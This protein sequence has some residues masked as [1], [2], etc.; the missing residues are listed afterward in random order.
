MDDCWDLPPT[1]TRHNLVH[2]DEDP[3]Q[4]PDQVSRSRKRSREYDPTFSSDPALFSSD[5]FLDTSADD[6]LLSNRKKKYR[7]TW[8]DKQAVEEP[9]F[10]NQPRKREFKR[11]T[12]SG[13]W[14]DED[15]TQDLMDKSSL[16]M[17]PSTFQVR[18]KSLS[19]R[20]TKRPP[21]DLTL[22]I[23]DSHSSGVY[24]RTEPTDEP[25]ESAEAIESRRKTTVFYPDISDAPNAAAARIVDR[26]VENGIAAVDLS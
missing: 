23:E 18:S 9:R 26:C 5:D 15:D 25:T 20:T 3:Y 13:I 6:Y 21:S 1:C 14:V 16:T 19:E 2:Q 10:G 24:N 11:N 22:A 7:G 17:P 4:L 12:D 8:W